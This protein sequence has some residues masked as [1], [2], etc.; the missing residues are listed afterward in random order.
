MIGPVQE[1]ETSTRV[2]AIKKIESR[3][4]VELAL[5]SIAVLHEE[6]SVISKPP[7]NEAAKTTNRAKRKILKMA[8]VLSALSEEGP[9]MS[10]TSRPSAT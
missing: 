5:A 6:G 2:S 8:L 1:N 10:V 7:R 9:Q 4:V 3:P